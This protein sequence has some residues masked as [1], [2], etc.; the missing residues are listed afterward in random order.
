MRRVEQIS[1]SHCGPAVVVMLLSYL[2]VD[3]SQESVVE[4]ADMSI[5]IENYGML[6]SDMARAVEK[7]TPQFQFWHKEGSSIPDLYQLVERY[8]YPA[9]VEWQGVF[10][11]DSDEDDGHYS[12]VTHVDDTSDI[13]FISDPYKRFAGVDRV[14]H[15]DEFANRWWDDNDIYSP[16]TGNIE[17]KRDNNMVFIIT[18]K[19]VVFP[20]ELGMLRG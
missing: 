10:F 12:V 6:V 20:E 3:V 18:G 15:T 5:A 8:K 13:I 4:R 1:T 7:I 14:F 17:T 2:G 19:E 9:A 11:E 16:E